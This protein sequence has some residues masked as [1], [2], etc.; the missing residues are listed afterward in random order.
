MREYKYT[1]LKDG[2][3]RQY[4]RRYK[5]IRPETEVDPNDSADEG[6][7]DREESDEKDSDKEGGF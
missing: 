1:R 2:V 5:V 4:T 6:F 7:G 3:E